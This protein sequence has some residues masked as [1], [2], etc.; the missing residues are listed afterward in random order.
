[1]DGFVKKASSSIT[2]ITESMPTI[3]STDAAL[4][5][6]F[7]STTSII[8][9]AKKQQS[10]PIVTQ[11]DVGLVISNLDLVP[12]IL[13]PCQLEQDTN[14]NKMAPPSISNYHTSLSNSPHISARFASNL[15]IVDLPNRSAAIG[16]E[17]YLP[18]YYYCHT[19]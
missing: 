11:F 9:V 14:P 16:H 18:S 13:F 5:R 15:S 8:R 17:V 3:K 19:F 2:A 1:M 6:D 7:Q 12:G 4:P 10:L